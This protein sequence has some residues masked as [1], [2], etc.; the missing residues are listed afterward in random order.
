M[1]ITNEERKMNIL[2]SIL[3]DFDEFISD[4]NNIEGKKVTMNIGCADEYS[5]D[6]TYKDSIEFVQDEWDK[7]VS[8]L[9][10]V[11]IDLEK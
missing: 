11:G 10:D 3:K 9:Y 2:I 6:M 8:N 4:A 7:V 1:K 5:Y